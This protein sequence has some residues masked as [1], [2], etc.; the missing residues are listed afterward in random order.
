MAELNRGLGP[1][2]GLELAL[3]H[4]RQHGGGARGAGRRGL[5][6]DGRRGE[7]RRA[8][9]VGGSRGRHLRGR[10][11]P[12]DQRLARSTSRELEPLTLK[13]KAE[14]VRGMGGGRAAEGG[15]PRPAPR[16]GN[17]ADRTRGGAAL[18]ERHCRTRRAGRRAASRDGRRP[19]RSGQVAAAARARARL[20]RAVAAGARSARALPGVRIRGGLLAAGG[21]APRQSAASAKG[22]DGALV[23]A[24]LDASVSGRCSPSGRAAEQVERR[25]AP[26]ARLL[27]AGDPPG[28]ARR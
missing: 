20:E 9:A 28:R 4:R 26:L 2:F 13:G 24:K 6:G 17:A 11:H 12:A 21:D 15:S 14:P 25:I 18:L 8:S 1:E 16:P 27:G 3:A 5:H 23:R 10:A 19:G 7:R 22:D